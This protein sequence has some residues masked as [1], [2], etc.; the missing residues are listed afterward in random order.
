MQEV[1]NLVEFLFMEYHMPRVNNINGVEVPL[2]AEEETAEDALEAAWEAEGKP[3]RDAA[4]A[5]EVELEAKLADNSITFEEMKEL[6][7][8]RG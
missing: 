8:L 3:L 2:T 5:R 4:N 7:R 1:L 6:M